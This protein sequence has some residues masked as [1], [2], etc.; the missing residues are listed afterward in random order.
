MGRGQPTGHYAVISPSTLD[1]LARTGDTFIMRY[2]GGKGTCYPQLINLMPPHQRYIETHLGGGAVMRYKRPAVEQ[3]GVDLDANVID[4]WRQESDLCTPVHA[5]AVDFLNSLELD[6]NTLIYADPPYLPE[7]RRR[8]RVYRCDYSVQ[9]HERLLNCLRALPC[10]VLISGYASPL[11]EGMLAGWSTHSFSV[12]THTGLREEHVWF[13]Y[14]KPTVLHDDRYLG[15]GFREREVIRRRQ[16]R[17]RS[18]IE[19]LSPTEQASLYRWLETVVNEE[20]G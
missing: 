13:N 5:D 9:D 1:T 16:D 7:T 18:R 6:S 20:N 8:A 19:R 10:R 2:D 12:Q 14:P 15:S 4:R 17:L 3:I 11:Y